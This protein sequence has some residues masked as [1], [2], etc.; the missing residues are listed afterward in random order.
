M[1]SSLSR[2]ITVTFTGTSSFDP[3][4]YVTVILPVILS[5][6]F[7]PSGIV[8]VTFP[9]LSTVITPGWSLSNVVP[10]GIFLPLSSF[11][12][13]STLVPGFPA[14]SSYFG[15]YSSLSRLVT[16]TF[17]GTS[18]FDPSG[19][20]T[21]I[22]PVILSPGFDPS[23]IV[24]VTFPSLS[25]AITPGWSLSNVVPLGISF[26]FVSFTGISTLVPGFP[27]PSSYFGV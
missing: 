25:T 7:D 15:V 23:G 12:G 4:G 9:S 8:T 1:Y 16:V 2:L 22:L 5:P 21:V 13:I 19:Y 11:T 26:L 17:T 10:S 3:S 24:T 18:S 27:F 14:S 20:V 6:G